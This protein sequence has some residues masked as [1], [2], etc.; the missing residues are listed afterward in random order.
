MQTKT[1]SDEMQSWLTDASNMQ[2]GYAERVLLPTSA[3]EIAEVLAE[4]TLTTT[5]VTVAGAGTGVTGGRIPFGGTV[6]ALDRLNAIKAIEANTARVEAGVILNDLQQAVS[7]RGLLYPPDPTEWSCQL[8]GTVATNASGARTFKYG[9]TRDYVTALQVVLATGKIIELRRG[10]FRFDA[11]GE[12]RLPLVS[13]KTLEV[14]LPAYRMPSTRKHAAGYYVAPEMDALDLFIGS[15]GTL[16]VI[17]EIEVRLLPQPENVL[18]GIVFFEEEKDLLALV[19]AARARSLATRATNG[20]GMDAR[21]LEYFDRAA[22]E[23]LR[24]HHPLVPESMAGAIF[25]EQ[26][27]T[28]A[29]EDELMSAWLELLEAHHARLD[30]SWFA[31]NDK[32]R[33]QLR[34]FRHHLPVLVNEWIAR[35]G[36]R[37][38]ST[39]MAL[40]DATFAEM[41]AFYQSSLRAAHLAYVIFGHIGDNHLHVNML[42]RNEAE[43]AQARALYTEFVKRAVAFGGTVS[44]EHGI[45]KIKRPYLEMLYG[46]AA[47]REMA[48]LKRTFDPAWILGRGNLLPV[49]AA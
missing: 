9:T 42:P 22:L 18:A 23:F 8:G 10:E 44:A 4:A 6:L 25:F 26:E 37:K 21:A 27:I 12:L 24:P 39:D 43:A 35:H 20:A 48:K 5:P 31:T 19:G 33:Q 38:V 17:T 32:D 30:D 46:E 28:A 11:K 16:G 13:G 3:E 41:L 29:H 47:L 2:G 40:P 15:E 34:A 1:S 45:G 49:P 14:Q 36:Q 7:Q